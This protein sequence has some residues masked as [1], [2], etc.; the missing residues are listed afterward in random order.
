MCSAMERLTPTSN[1]LASIMT[2]AITIT[3]HRMRRYCGDMLSDEWW[4][5]LRPASDAV[6]PCLEPPVLRGPPP[7]TPGSDSWRRP[8][9]LTYAV[10]VAVPSTDAALAVAD[11]PR[12]DGAS[13][14]WYEMI[15]MLSSYVSDV[16]F[17]LSINTADYTR[18]NS[19]YTFRSA[20]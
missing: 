10:A 13:S 7:P 2:E 8:L 17:R 5:C 18:L 1:I 20:V 15:S 16:I 6:T 12:P 14:V 3:A 19:L 11:T 9:K 4:W